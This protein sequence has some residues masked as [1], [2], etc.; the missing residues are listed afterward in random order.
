[1]LKKYFKKVRFQKKQHTVYFALGS[2][3]RMQK[4]D[5]P[6]EPYPQKYAMF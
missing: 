6:V 4:L 3:L 5:W 2:S 1:M